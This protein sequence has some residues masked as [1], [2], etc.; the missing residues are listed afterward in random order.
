MTDRREVDLNADPITGEPGSHPVGT[1]I[2][3]VGGAAAGAAIGSI[4]GP[5]GTLIGGAIGAIVGGGAG[6][7][8]GEAFDP[9]VEY[10]Y[11]RDT[12]TSTPYYREGYDYDKDY[13]PA[14]ATGYASRA[15]YDK[16]ARFEDAEHDLKNKWAEVKGESR[17]QWE[18]AK[19]AVRDGWDKTHARINDEEYHPRVGGVQGKE[20]AHP[21]ATGTGT[22]G[23]AAA[24]AAVGS[25]AGP[26]GSVVGGVVGAVAGAAAGNKAADVFEGN[27]DEDTYWR[28]N[29]TNAS[30]YN[31]KYDYDTDYRSA[32][33]YGYTQRHKYGTNQSFDVIEADLRRDWESAK[34][35][36][37]LAWE[38]AKDADRAGDGVGAGPDFI[39]R[40]RDP[41][42]ARRRQRAHRY[43]HLLASLARQLQLA[44]DDLRGEGA[45]ARAV[46]AQDDGLDLAVL[47]RL[48]DELGG[49]I[50]A[51]VSGR[52]LAVED[53]ALGHH[54]RDRVAAAAG[55]RQ[56]AQRT[57]PAPPPRGRS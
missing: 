54:H 42:A 37:R 29:H 52:L 23:G 5:L 8:A 18:E 12:H 53:G 10:E 6:H 25:A 17:L 33:S 38:D 30:Y 4:A 20:K 43:D 57:R 51:D 46:H 49:G 36:S 47:T 13:H 55:A 7:A 48:P 39:G 31:D 3:G 2:G 22:L 32:Y 1:A 45:A 9:T 15:H 24:G 11:W 56:A 27:T 44:A 28:N 21:V 14:Y 19:E 35:H 16:N 26:V 40:G 34:G 41:I 50:A